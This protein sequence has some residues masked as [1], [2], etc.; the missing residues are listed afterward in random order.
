MS[1]LALGTVSSGQNAP[2]SCPRV[3]TDRQDTTVTGGCTDEDGVRFEGSLEIHNLPGLEIENPA[4]DPSQ[5]SSIELDF[6]VTSP[7]GEDVVLDGKVE[8]N[9]ADILG[10]LTIEAQGI[11]S[12][13]RLAMD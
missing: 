10:D 4:Y 1:A 9:V 8:R 3:V 13:S 7:Q 6:R 12:I 2:T 5:S 11:E